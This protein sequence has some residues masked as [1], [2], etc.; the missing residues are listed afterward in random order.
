LYQQ[1]DGFFV[2]AVT[3]I[4]MNDTGSVLFRKEPLDWVSYAHKHLSLSESINL[5]IINYVIG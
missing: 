4:E 5:S 3:I 1:G 2:D